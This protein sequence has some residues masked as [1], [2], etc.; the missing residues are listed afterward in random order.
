MLGRRVMI[1]NPIAGEQW[2]EYRRIEL[3][4]IVT[5]QYSGYAEPA[6]DIFHHEVHHLLFNYDCQGL[7]LC[8]LGVVVNSNNGKLDRTLCH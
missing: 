1:G 5:S 2:F 3:C 8:L 7:D 6:T 4:T